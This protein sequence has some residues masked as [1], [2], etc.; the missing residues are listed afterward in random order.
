M[1]IHQEIAELSFEEFIEQAMERSAEEESKRF[2]KTV[3]SRSKFNEQKFYDK[4]YVTILD[5]V[6][7]AIKT[8]A[9]TF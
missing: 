7:F 3:T 1:K 5:F 8:L 9:F 2:M 6:Y 4:R